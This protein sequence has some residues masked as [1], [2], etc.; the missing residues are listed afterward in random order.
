MVSL[1]VLLLLLQVPPAAPQNLPSYTGTTGSS[2]APIS[3]PAGYYSISVLSCPA[4]S[5]CPGTDGTI[6]NG[7][8]C[9]YPCPAGTYNPLTGKMLAH[10]HPLGHAVGLQLAHGHA[11][12]H[13]HKHAH[14]HRQLLQLLQELLELP[15]WGVIVAP[16]FLPLLQAGPGEHLHQRFCGRGGVCVWQRQPHRGHGDG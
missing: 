6:P 16:R 8:G 2:C 4:G 13:A 9:K 15:R 7:D 14:A 10:A 5:V 11:P 1:G 12:Q 3:M